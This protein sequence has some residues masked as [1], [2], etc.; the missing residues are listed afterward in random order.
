MIYN[1]SISLLW[2]RIV[3]RP[4]VFFVENVMWDIG[5]THENGFE[6]NKPRISC[7]CTINYL[8]GKEAILHLNPKYLSISIEREHRSKGSGKKVVMQ[9]LKV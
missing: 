8:A 1:P 6:E 3:C 4:N 7:K 5:Y 2:V 9:V